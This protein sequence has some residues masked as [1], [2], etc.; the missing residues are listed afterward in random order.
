[1]YVWYYH[2]VQECLQ[3]SHSDW[4]LDRVT[5]FYVEEKTPW[6][7]IMAAIS[8]SEDDPPQT[9]LQLVVEISRNTKIF[10]KLF[11]A[12]LIRMIF[13]F[14]FLNIILMSNYFARYTR[15]LIGSENKNKIP[16]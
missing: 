12:P 10:D 16:K 13:I 4:K 14:F 2:N 15:L 5:S 11:Y 6:D 7:D 8:S 1:V 3:V 9:S